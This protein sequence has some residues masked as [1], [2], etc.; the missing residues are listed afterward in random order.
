[1]LN[2]VE[3]LES[4]GGV[5][6]FTGEL[7]RYAILRAT[8]REVSEIKK[9]REFVDQLMAQL[10]QFEFRNGQLRKKYDGIKYTLKKM[11]VRRCL[12]R[13]CVIT[14]TNLNLIALQTLIYELSL[15]NSGETVRPKSTAEEGDEENDQNGDER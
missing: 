9:C 7:N 5:M 12:K 14:S 3:L 13:V 6:D 11:E 2:Q 4:A 15:T 10:M 8:N 1:M